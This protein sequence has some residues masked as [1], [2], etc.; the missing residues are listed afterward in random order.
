[1]RPHASHAVLVALAIS[2]IPASARAYDIELGSDG[3]GGA[4]NVTTDTVLPL[5]PDGVFHFT[6]ITVAEGATLSF[7]YTEAFHPGIVL[8]ATGDVVVDGRID[9]G[10]EDATSAGAGRAGAG[11][12]SGGRYID[13]SGSAG[14]VPLR[15][16][17][18]GVDGDSYRVAGGQ[19]GRSSQ[20]SCIGGHGGGGGGSLH[21]F[22]NGTV[23]GSGTIS[24]DGGAAY[25]PAT[26]ACTTAT[27][28]ARPGVPGGLVVTSSRFE[29]AAL[30]LVG[31]GRVHVHSLDIASNAIV[32]VPVTGT[33]SIGYRSH[34]RPW[35]P[36]P[37]V[38]ITHIDGDPV[39]PADSVMLAPDSSPVIVRVR[40]LG[41]TGSR[42][43]ATVQ[44]SHF[45]AGGLVYTGSASVAG[46]TGD[47][48]V[49][50]IVDVGGDNDTSYR[51]YP[52]VAC[53]P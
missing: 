13:A 2:T 19:G 40:M 6:T 10:G 31:Q 44:L 49:D 20:S 36:L 48:S 25:N 28:Q 50:V 39:A 26:T 22:A 38:V 3:S 21:I 16:S 12:T 34:V 15:P 51:V 4:L 23:R 43:T 46:P 24:V 45:D 1:M 14:R 37:S 9:A 27:Y 53:T 35:T 8:L 33:G 17:G 11:G 5:P 52:G 41:C 29:G 47:D 7:S 18:T 32:G 42:V 30:T